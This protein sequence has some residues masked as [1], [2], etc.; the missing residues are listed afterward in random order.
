[1]RVLRSGLLSTGVRE[2]LLLSV[3]QS[4]G[5]SQT[6]GE[7]V[8]QRFRGSR[9]MSC[10]GRLFAAVDRR[11]GTGIIGCFR[12]TIRGAGAGKHL[13]RG[14]RVVRKVVALEFAAILLLVLA[15]CG[16]TAGSPG[17]TA[18]PV[19]QSGAGNWVTVATLSG[20]ADQQGPLFTLSGAPAQLTC[21]VVSTSGTPCFEATS[22]NCSWQLSLEE[23]H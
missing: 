9:P 7:V 14:A 10:G 13:E 12:V 23:R 5:G 19:A 11:L 1:V 21:E 15:G 3:N 22:A 6:P 17:S 20:T 2:G 4:S 8:L 18:Q 16:G